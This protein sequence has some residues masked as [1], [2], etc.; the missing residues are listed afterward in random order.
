MRWIRQLP[1]VT[2][3]DFRT[4]D[5]DLYDWLKYI[6]SHAQARKGNEG[7]KRLAVVSRKLLIPWVT[8][9]I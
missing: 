7:C 2:V 3:I 1:M 5:C 6:H 9:V 4:Q 8:L